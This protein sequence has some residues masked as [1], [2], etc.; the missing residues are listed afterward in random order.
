MGEP[1][2][3]EPIFRT[4]SVKLRFFSTQN[5]DPMGTP[6]KTNMS[7][8]K[9][10]TFNRNYIFQ[11]SIFSGSMFIFGGLMFFCPHP[12]RGKANFHKSPNF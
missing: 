10:R 1:I 5:M 2:F 7:L 4:R 6:Q 12:Q 8:K 11:P 3:Q 9:G